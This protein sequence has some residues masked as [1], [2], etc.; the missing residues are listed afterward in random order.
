MPRKYE[1]FLS[2]QK[3]VE[4]KRKK[5]K[6]RL[7]PS[8]EKKINPISRSFF[9]LSKW[10]VDISLSDTVQILFWKFTAVYTN[11]LTLI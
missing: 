6:A 4:K 1:N 3:K 5:N 11:H 8:N 9:S 2:L 10:G 7:C